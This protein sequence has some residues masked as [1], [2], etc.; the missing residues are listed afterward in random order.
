V[1][2]ASSSSFER[3]TERRSEGAAHCDGHRIGAA[4]FERGGRQIA[5]VI[6]WPVIDCLDLDKMSSFW[7]QALDFEH[8]YT[9][10]SGGYLLAA[11]DGSPHRLAL[12]PCPE[13]KS[14]KN[15]LHLDLRPDDQQVEVERLEQ[16]GARKIDIGQRDVSWVVMGDPEGN[17][18]CVLAAR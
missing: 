3:P 2:S 18:F 7:S 6:D 16:L 5:L 9:G 12:L 17:E 14:S 8:V 10:P 11:K 13:T 1:K 15:R 4:W